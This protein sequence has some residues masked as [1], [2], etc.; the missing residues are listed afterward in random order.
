MYVFKFS[1]NSLLNSFFFYFL[2]SFFNFVNFFLDSAL[3]TPHSATRN[4]QSSF[5]EQ[6]KSKSW[7]AQNDLG[8]IPSLPKIK[9][10]SKPLVFCKTRI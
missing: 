9:E 6:P 10:A 3:R 5:S 8:K 4:P 7:L 2:N 1:F